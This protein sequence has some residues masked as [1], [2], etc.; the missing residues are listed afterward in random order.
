MET[1]TDVLYLCDRRACD[2]CS[3]PECQHTLDIAHA[4]NFTLSPY[5]F[6]IEKEKED[7]K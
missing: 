2:N 7:E 6:F 4:V 3:W 5:G 1:K